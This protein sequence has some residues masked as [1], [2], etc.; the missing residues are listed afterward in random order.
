MSYENTSCTSYCVYQVFEYL[1]KLSFFN[2]K[3]AK[4][5][6]FYNYVILCICLYKFLIIALV[7]WITKY[8][9]TVTYAPIWSSV[10]DIFDK[11]SKI[12]L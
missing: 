10:F 11:L 4:A 2:I 6:C 9:F 5:F 8:C 7:E 1:E 12:K 3:K